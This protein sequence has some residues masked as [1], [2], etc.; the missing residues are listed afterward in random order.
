V[1]LCSLPDANGILPA[2][3]AG[4]CVGDSRDEQLQKSNIYDI[5]REDTRMIIKWAMIFGCFQKL[6]PDLIRPCSLFRMAFYP[7]A[8]QLFAKLRI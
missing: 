6:T 1:R 7:V 4:L 2:G 8:S 5:A 3:G